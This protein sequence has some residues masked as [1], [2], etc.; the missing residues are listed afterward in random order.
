MSLQQTAQNKIR[1]HQALHYFAHPATPLPAS[2]T[3]NRMTVATKSDPKA[4]GKSELLRDELEFYA[5]R[6]RQWQDA[7]RDVYFGFRGL[8]G[9][10][11]RSFYVKSN[12]CTICFFQETTSSAVKPGDDEAR[13]LPLLEMCRKLREQTTSLSSQP[14]YSANDGDRKRKPKP[15]LCAVMSQSTARV[16]KALHRLN[17]EYATP[18]S[19]ASSTQ[20]DIGQFHLL[21]EELTAMESHA[22]TAAASS[23]APLPLQQNVHGADSLLYFTGHQT[24]HG[25][26]EFLINRKR[27]Y[28]V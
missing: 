17:I 13:D 2:I 7:F 8:R 3:L 12:D 27:A 22:R 15:R 18:Y 1:W 21:E 24:V 14:E 19:S 25:L 10:E 26:Y 20:R 6:L 16:R 11:R 23:R 5:T 28:C 9:S 4:G